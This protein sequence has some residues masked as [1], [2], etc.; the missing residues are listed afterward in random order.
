M[1][2]KTIATHLFVPMAISLAFGVL[3][4]TL[5]TLLLVPC[6]YMV[7]EDF[8]ALIGRREQQQ[9]NSDLIN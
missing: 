9:G 6:L 8:L 5:I 2:D 7:V 1:L 3:I 4:G